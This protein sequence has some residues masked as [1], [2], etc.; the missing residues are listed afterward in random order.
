MRRLFVGILVAVVSFAGILTQHCKVYDISS[1]YGRFCTMSGLQFHSPPELC[2]H[3]CLEWDSCIAFSYNATD[4]T[5]TI[6]SEPCPLALSVPEMDKYMFA[7]FSEKPLAQCFLWLPFNRHEPVDDRPVIFKHHYSD[8]TVARLKK[9]NVTTLG[10]EVLGLR[11]CFASTPDSGKINGIIEKWKCER[12][13]IVNGCT[14]I[15]VPYN[16]GESLPARAVTGGAMPS[17]DVMYVA[18]LQSGGR[19]FCGY[20]TEEGQEAV[21]TTTGSWAKSTRMELLVIL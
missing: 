17:G 15:W 21:A 14:A 8:A 5:C 11:G 9:N 16:A 13:R 6:T 10:Y 1:I 7:V 18:K 12:L 19:V 4:G 3:A 2:I 20:Y